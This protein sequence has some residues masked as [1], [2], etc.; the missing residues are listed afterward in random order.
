MCV[1]VEL[2]GNEPPPPPNMRSRTP[3]HLTRA[4]PVPAAVTIPLPAFTVTRKLGQDVTVT[5]SGIKGLKPG[6]G[7]VILGLPLF[8]DRFTYASRA[9]GEAWFSD[10]LGE[11]G[12]QSLGLLGEETPA[13]AAPTPAPAATPGSGA[14]KIP[15]GGMWTALAL[16]LAALAAS[17]L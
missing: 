5:A 16:G 2:G 10:L 13:A 4:P 3:I 15:A 11:A 8:V 7:H 17:W 6:D 12:C 9:A 1:C 14:N